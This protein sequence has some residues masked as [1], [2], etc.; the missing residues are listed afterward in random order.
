MPTPITRIVIQASKTNPDANI[1]KL[2]TPATPYGQNEPF[3]WFEIDSCLVHPAHFSCAELL[4]MVCNR[5]F[6]KSA[7]HLREV[8]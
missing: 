4:Q 2:Q 5:H 7:F 3:T 8:E 6:T 1:L